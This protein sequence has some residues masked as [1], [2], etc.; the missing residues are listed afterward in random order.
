M[1]T[2]LG[3]AAGAAGEIPAHIQTLAL[4]IAHERPQVREPRAVDARLA[5]RVVLH[6]AGL[7]RPIAQLPAFVQTKLDVAEIRQADLC[8]VAVH[9]P[10][11]G[12]DRGHILLDDGVVDQGPKGIPRAPAHPG[13]TSIDRQSSVA[14][15]QQTAGSGQR[16][17]GAA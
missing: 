11:L 13:R 17:P 6:A 2:Y 10:G 14:A 15:A 7:L 12:G 9:R 8:S 16:G 5:L 1:I 4:P 3:L